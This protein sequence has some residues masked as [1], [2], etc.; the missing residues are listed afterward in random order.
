MR[1]IGLVLSLVGGLAIA[2]TS[3]AWADGFKS[4]RVCGGTAFQTCAAVEVTVVGSNVTMR[5]WNLSGNTAATGVTTPGGTIINGI[6]FFNVPAGVSIN[7]VSGLTVGG[8]VRGTDVPSGWNLKNFGN[9]V[10]AVDYSTATSRL[11]GGIASGCATAGQLPGTPPNL[12]QNPCN[13]NFGNASNWVTFNFQ[14]QGGSWDPSTSDI[15]IRAYDG[16]RNQGTECWTGISP[17][18]Q[19][20]TCTDVTVTPEPVTMTLL[21]TGLAGLGGAGIVRRRRNKNDVA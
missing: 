17:Y 7:T 13:S 1:K 5:I 16:I 19:A 6:G 10:F 9:N 2:G 12:Y 4:W 15:S 14:I 11:N 8:P 20:A 21:A 18:G 3:T